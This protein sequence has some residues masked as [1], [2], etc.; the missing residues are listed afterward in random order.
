[1][2][3]HPFLSAQS[4]YGFKYNRRKAGGQCKIGKNS[5]KLDGNALLTYNKM[6]YGEIVDIACLLAS[7]MGDTDD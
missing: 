6:D 4:R 7:R 3:V 5:K 1:M 2:A